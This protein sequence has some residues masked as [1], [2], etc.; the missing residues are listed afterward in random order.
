MCMSV[1]SVCIFFLNRQVM[2]SWGFSQSSTLKWS[3]TALPAPDRQHS[4]HHLIFHGFLNE[5]ASLIM[6][7]SR[8]CRGAALKTHRRWL[9][10]IKKV[11]QRV[12]RHGSQCRLEARWPWAGFLVLFCLGCACWPGESHACYVGVFP[13]WPSTCAKC[14]C[15]SLSSCSW[16][17]SLVSCL[18]QNW[19][20]MFAFK[21]LHGLAPS[22]L[23]KAR[24]CPWSR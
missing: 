6:R 21:A 1:C 5:A 10:R 18:F 15:P 23:S 16:L 8:A 11:T 9:G 20:L 17:P 14:C 24:N 12:G 7:Q 3:S 4:Q 13:S 19:F 22:Y 2:T